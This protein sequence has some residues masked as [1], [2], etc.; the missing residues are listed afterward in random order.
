[1]LV[2]QPI[3]IVSNNA[4]I[5]TFCYAFGLP[6]AV[7]AF[8]FPPKLLCG[9]KSVAETSENIGDRCLANFGTIIKN[10]TG[11]TPSELLGGLLGTRADSRAEVQRGAP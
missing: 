9:G 3:A 11:K 8:V 1:M 2:L 5:K 4:K 10:A 7:L 6:S